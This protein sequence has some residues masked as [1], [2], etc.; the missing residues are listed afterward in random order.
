MSCQWLF[1]QKLWLV[2][3][4]FWPAVRRATLLCARAHTD[5]RLNLRGQRVEDSRLKRSL[6]ALSTW[7][8]R[9]S[10][11]FRNVILA[12]WDSFFSAVLPKRSEKYNGSNSYS[13]TVQSQGGREQTPLG[14]SQTQPYNSLLVGIGKQ[15]LFTTFRCD[16]H[17][18]SSLLSLSQS[19]VTA[20]AIV[21]L[22]PALS[23]EGFLKLAR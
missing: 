19:H 4:S 7:S 14:G 16:L 10:P 3:L 13:R 15:R 2:C 23:R 1:G 20:A 18:F 22:G 21:G 9:E 11:L 12:L 8:E 6:R 5:N 17:C